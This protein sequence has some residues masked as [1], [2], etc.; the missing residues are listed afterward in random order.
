MTA[1]GAA[2]LARS[3]R[4]VRANTIIV[5]EEIPEDRYG[6]Q[7]TPAVRSVAQMLAH[8]AVAPRG[9]QRIHA[10][11]V[12]LYEFSRFAA[13][14]ERRRA[15][16]AALTSKAEILEVLRQEG[17]SFA[18]WLESLSD[19]TLAERVEFPPPVQPS[20]KTRFEMLLSVKE[21]E[22]HHRSQ[23]MLIQ[24]LLGQVPHLT[25]RIEERMAQRQQ[26]P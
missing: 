25:R 1:Y 12:T 24:R 9:M 4:T 23:L 14:L 19:A 26:Q 7:A 13:A 10:E 18:A 21:H 8:V 11:G 5:A 20:S 16:E 22:M 17:V 3:F 2:D 15:E 6:F